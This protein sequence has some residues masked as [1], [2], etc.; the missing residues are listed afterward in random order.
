MCHSLDLFV[1]LIRLKQNNP[2]TFP[3]EITRPIT[4]FGSICLNPNL[5][6][7]NVL[8]TPD[9]KIQPSICEC[10]NQTYKYKY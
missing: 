8:Y 3:D 7:Y 6:I 1:A 10:P 5:T 4:H 9:F 2:I